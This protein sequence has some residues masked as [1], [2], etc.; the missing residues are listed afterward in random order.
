MLS[1]SPTPSDSEDV[2]PAA[3]SSFWAFISGAISPKL[4]WLYLLIQAGTTFLIG[5]IARQDHISLSL[6]LALT[7]SSVAMHFRPLSVLVV[8]LGS[9][10]LSVIAIVL[11]ASISSRGHFTA[12]NNWVPADYAVLLLFLVGY[13]T[14]YVQQSRMHTQLLNAHEQLTCAHEQL[15][16]SSQ[17]IEALTL[18]TERQRLAREL[19]DTLAQGLVG[20]ALQLETI[21]GLLARGHLQQAQAIVQ[22]AGKAV[23]ATL[24]EAR[25]AID[26]LRSASLADP[27]FQEALRAEIARFI[28]TTGVACHTDFTHLAAIAPPLREHVLRVLAEGLTNIARHARASAAWVTIAAEDDTMWIEVRDNGVGFDP[29]SLNAQDGHYGFIGLRERARLLDGQCE[30][31]SQPGAGTTLRWSW[32]SPGRHSSDHIL[33]GSGGQR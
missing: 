19:H 11:N 2:M 29:A 20:F 23:R 16:Q 33:P 13:T 22:L 6:Y 26:D 17:R 30:I 31:S 18:L 27:A 4:S 21:D 1:A 25:G 14:L 10:A 24:H 3:L 7:L 32:T 5:L 28:S 9:F 8:A 15:E 12:L